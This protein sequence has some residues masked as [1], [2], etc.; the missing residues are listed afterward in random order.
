MRYISA[1]TGRIFSSRTT[2]GGATLFSLVYFL[3][4]FS[5]ISEYGVT[6]DEPLHR[7]WGKVLSFFWQ[8]GDRNVLDLMPGN[9]V[10]YGPLFFYINYILSDFLY[11]G[12]WLTFVEANH[13]LTLILSTFVVGFTYALGQIFG[14]RKVGFF[15]ACFLVLFPQFIAHAHYNPKDI[16]LMAVIALTSLVFLFALRLHSRALIIGSAF[17]FGLSV[18]VK[19]NALLMAPVFGIT[20][21]LWAFFHAPRSSLFIVL[22]HQ[23]PVFFSAV[24]A[25][26]FG[27]YLCWPSAWGDWSLIPKSIQFFLGENYWSGTVLFFGVEY[28]GKELPF[29]YVPFELAVSMPLLM[30]LAFFTGLAAVFFGMRRSQMQVEY[31]FLFLWVVF[32][33]L[34]SIKPGLVRYDGMRQF[35]FIMPAIAVIS[36]IG[37]QQLIARLKRKSKNPLSGTIFICLVFFSLITQVLSVHPFEGSYRNEILQLIYHKNLDQV[38]SIEY[39]GSSYKQGVDWLTENA[40]PNSVICVPTAGILVTWYPWR[41][42]FS[43]ECSKE[44]DYVMFFT[45]YGKDDAYRDLK[46]PVFSIERLKSTLLVIY[47]IT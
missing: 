11:E 43:F 25:C 27:M 21:F 19:I 3:I 17:L 35:Y 6:W 28:A 40:E 46:D 22:R 15:S 1:I 29:Y 12:G 5:Q 47:Q 34:Y 4:Q 41:E 10:H 32:P 44:S 39:W 9:G 2:W 45:R 14:G 30:L 42:D 33:L 38:F 31:I 16:P 18:A 24:V 8:T 26:I 23:T 13:I 7:N 36:A 20:Y 37:L